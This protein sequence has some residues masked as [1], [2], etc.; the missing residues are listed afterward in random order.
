MLLV[1]GVSLLCGSETWTVKA[2]RKVNILNPTEM[3]FLDGF[4]GLN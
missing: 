4:M 3:N 1:L 2:E